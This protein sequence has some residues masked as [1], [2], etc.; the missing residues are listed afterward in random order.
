MR[1]AWLVLP[2]L[3]L[4]AMLLYVGWD[5]EAGAVGPGMAP[6]PENAGGGGSIL[7]GGEAEVARGSRTVTPDGERIGSGPVID[8]RSR[9]VGLSY[10]LEPGDLRGWEAS[11]EWMALRLGPEAIPDLVRMT[12]DAE[13]D[14]HAKVALAN[15]LST[16]RSLQGKRIYGVSTRMVGRISEQVG[17]GLRTENYALDVAAGRALAAWG[18]DGDRARMMQWTQQGDAHEHLLLALEEAPTFEVAEALAHGPSDSGMDHLAEWVRLQEWTLGRMDIE[19]LSTWM[20]ERL[21]N[22]EAITGR[23]DA[24]RILIRLGDEVI[25]RAITL[26]LE[27]EVATDARSIELAPVLVDRMA[28]SALLTKILQQ[29]GSQLAE[30]V[31]MEQSR[32]E[33]LKN[34]RGVSFGRRRLVSVFEIDLNDLRGRG[35]RAERVSR[36]SGEPLEQLQAE[37]DSQIQDTSGSRAPFLLT[38]IPDLDAQRSLTMLGLHALSDQRPTVSRHAGQQLERILGETDAKAFLSE[39]ASDPTG[40]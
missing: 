9:I 25:D 20:I 15:V 38:V 19:I 28:D 2:L 33:D 16:L 12:F 23:L 26:Y 22:T 29:E 18:H 17:S 32:L 14:L 30:S 10:A 37:L 31:R 27:S 4:G 13:L 8:L 40:D 35:D 39:L 1:F 21:V 24:A 6:D 7:V 11:V 36:L 34:A 3:L 5:A